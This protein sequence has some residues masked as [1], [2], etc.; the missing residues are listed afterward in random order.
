[1]ELIFH[2]TTPS[3]W[4]KQQASEVF[5]AESLATEGFIHCSTAAQTQGVIE[6]YF[7]G[8]NTLIKLSIDPSLLQSELRYEIATGGQSFPH[9]Y[10]PI[11]KKAILK[12]EE[13]A[14]A[15]KIEP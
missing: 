2:L 12:L 15:K 1:M 14:V 13:L 7:Q 5:E 6:R 8:L 11:Q 3:E 9:I 10:G 4:K